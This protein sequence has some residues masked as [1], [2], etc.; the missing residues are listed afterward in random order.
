M[1]HLGIHCVKTQSL[2]LLYMFVKMFMYFGIVSIISSSNVIVFVSVDLFHKEVI[3]HV[4][5][6]IGYT[7]FHLSY[8]VQGY[9]L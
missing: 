7:W 3:T 1:F 6:Y 2:D 9:N 5:V 4:C 8:I